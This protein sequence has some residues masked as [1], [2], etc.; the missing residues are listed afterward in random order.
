VTDFAVAAAAE[1]LAAEFPHHASTTV[2]RVVTDCAEEFPD[3]DSWF[4][5]ASRQGTVE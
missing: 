4:R 5:R 3:G 1:K 2:I